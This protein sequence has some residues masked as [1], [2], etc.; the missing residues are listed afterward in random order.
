MHLDPRKVAVLL[1]YSTSCVFLHQVL[2]LHYYQQC[3]AGFF[4]AFVSKGTP[5][6]TLIHNAVK[7]LQLSP[8]VVLN[9]ARGLLNNT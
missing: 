8:L 3:E 4:A 2:Q 9:T 7:C 6:C 5:Y 1:A